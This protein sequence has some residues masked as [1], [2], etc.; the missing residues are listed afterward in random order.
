MQSNRASAGRAMCNG[1]TQKFMR[2]DQTSF[3]LTHAA[4][5]EV[6]NHGPVPA[7]RATRSLDYFFFIAAPQ[8]GFWR[9]GSVDSK[10]PP[11]ALQLRKRVGLG[12]APSSH[13]GTTRLLTALLWCEIF[14]ARSGACVALKPLP[15]DFSWA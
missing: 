12:F 1:L 6:N 15:R 5:D 7:L 14:E 4:F 2:R 13:D 10:W 8:E 3:W 11:P 9:I